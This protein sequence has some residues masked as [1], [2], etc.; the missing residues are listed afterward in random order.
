MRVFVTGASG[1]IGSAIV[2]ELID[3][4]MGARPGSLGWLR[5]IAAQELMHIAVRWKIS[6]ALQRGGRC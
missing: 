1:F 5:V 4:D 3:A 6:R 2:R